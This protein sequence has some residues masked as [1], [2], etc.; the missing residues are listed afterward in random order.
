M[1]QKFMHNGRWVDG[2]E[3]RR[4]RGLDKPVEAVEEVFEEEAVADETS[5][6]E[7]IEVEDNPK[8]EKKR[9]RPAKKV[10]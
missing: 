6:S 9:G 8:I 7:E 4:L 2:Q 5:F 10:K 1:S 3:F